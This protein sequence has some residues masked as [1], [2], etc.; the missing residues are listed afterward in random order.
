MESEGKKKGHEEPSGKR[1]IK[2]GVE[3]FWFV[4]FA[5]V[6][7]LNGLTGDNSKQPIWHQPTCKTLENLTGASHE[8]VWDGSSTPLRVSCFPVP[9]CRDHCGFIVSLEIR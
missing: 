7:F 1:G 2:T 4:V 6:C 8:L 5:D 3:E 9:H